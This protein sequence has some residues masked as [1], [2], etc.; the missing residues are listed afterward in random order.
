MSLQIDRKATPSL[1]DT[2][3]YELPMPENKL[4]LWFTNPKSQTHQ[5]T[6]PKTNPNIPWNRGRNSQPWKPA[7]CGECFLGNAW[8]LELVNLISFS[9]LWKKPKVPQIL[10]C[11]RMLDTSS[12]F[13]KTRPGF[14]ESNWGAIFLGGISHRFQVVGKITGCIVPEIR[15]LDIVIR[16]A[17]ARHFLFLSGLSCRWYEAER[18]GAAPFVGKTCHALKLT[19]SRSATFWACPTLCL[20]FWLLET[21]AQ[22]SQRRPTLSYASG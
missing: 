19:N 13:A 10:H 12:S 3:G 2:N 4:Y 7:A 17:N 5:Q 20:Y 22:S 6:S 14:V 9:C 8:L 1:A 16:W 21:Q 15:S 11:L 18:R